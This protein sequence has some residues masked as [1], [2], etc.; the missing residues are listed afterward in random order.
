MATRTSG[1]ATWASVQCP[2]VNSWAYR[3]LRAW[4]TA[5]AEHRRLSTYLTVGGRLLGDPAACASAGPASTPCDVSSSSRN[6][7][8]FLDSGLSCRR[9]VEASGTESARDADPVGW[10]SSASRW[11]VRRS[12]YWTTLGSQ[13]AGCGWGRHQR[14]VDRGR[15]V[16]VLRICRL[17]LPLPRRTTPSLWLCIQPGGNIPM[18]LDSAAPL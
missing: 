9:A 4:H 8:N 5:L 2:A 15:A 13:R 12:V 14:G 11:R 3:I 1:Q 17:H 10:E 7:Q 18:R 16:T 6:P